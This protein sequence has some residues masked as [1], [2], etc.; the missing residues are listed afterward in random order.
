LGLP[1][2]YTPFCSGAFGY[3]AMEAAAPPGKEN[4][5]SIK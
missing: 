1:D 3:K 2:Q 4:I 5:V